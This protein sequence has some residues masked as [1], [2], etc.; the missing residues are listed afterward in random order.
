MVL[1][2]EAAALVG[3]RAVGVDGSICHILLMFMLKDVFSSIQ[4]TYT[5]EISKQRGAADPYSVNCEVAFVF[6]PIRD[7]YRTNGLCS[8]Y[9]FCHLYDYSGRIQLTTFSPQIS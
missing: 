3:C 2:L 8:G 1:L 4:I 9:T 7:V 6:R 5:I